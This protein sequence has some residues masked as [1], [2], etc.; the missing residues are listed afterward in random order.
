M[1][2]FDDVKIRAAGWTSFI[3]NKAEY[4]GENSHSLPSSASLCSSPKQLVCYLSVVR[5]AS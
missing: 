5:D 4:G 1:N 3:G 2:G